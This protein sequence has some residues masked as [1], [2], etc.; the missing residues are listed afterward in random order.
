MLLLGMLLVLIIIQ[1][2]YI[3]NVDTPKEEL[4]DKVSV[5]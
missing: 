3:L 4:K 2:Q 1:V 5:S